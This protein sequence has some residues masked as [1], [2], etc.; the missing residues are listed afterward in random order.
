M[1]FIKRAKN[2]KLVL[3]KIIARIRSKKNTEE[4][5]SKEGHHSIFFGSLLQP[6]IK[7]EGGPKVF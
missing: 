4:D 2:K 3:Q 5:V 6:Q 7:K 1:F